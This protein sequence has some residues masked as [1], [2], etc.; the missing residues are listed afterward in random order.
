MKTAAKLIKS[1]LKSD[2]ICYPSKEDVEDHSNKLAPLLRLFMEEL[3]ADKAII[4]RTGNHE[5]CKTLVLYS[6]ITFRIGRRIRS[7]LVP[8]QSAITCSKLTKETLEQGAIY[9]QS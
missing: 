8:T 6:I 2:K 1:E 4:L 7:H 3:V 9:V 5:S